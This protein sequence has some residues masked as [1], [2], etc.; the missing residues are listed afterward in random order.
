MNKGKTKKKK[1]THEKITQ[2]VYTKRIYQKQ[3]K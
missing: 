1:K 2:S 3:K